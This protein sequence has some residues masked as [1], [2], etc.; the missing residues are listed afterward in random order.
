M[1][2]WR[3]TC[4]AKQYPTHRPQLHA[5]EYR[6]IGIIQGLGEQQGHETSENLIMN[7]EK[8]TKSVQASLLKAQSLAV[9]RNHTALTPVHVLHAMLDEKETGALSNM[10]RAMCNNRYLQS[11]QQ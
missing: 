9:N 8:F 5:L 6:A 4:L 11:P 3:A 10:V 2:R 7:Q 1:T